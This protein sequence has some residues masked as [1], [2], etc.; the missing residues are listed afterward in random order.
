MFSHQPRTTA[1]LA[2]TSTLAEHLPEDGQRDHPLVQS[3]A[4]DAKGSVYALVGAGT[5]PVERYRHGRS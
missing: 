5:E 4:A 2:L 3:F 1:V